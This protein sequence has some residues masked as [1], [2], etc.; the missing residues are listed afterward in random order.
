M[1]SHVASARSRTSTGKA[2]AR[3]HPVGVDDFLTF[4][5]TATIQDLRLGATQADV[6]AALGPPADTSAIKPLIW[7]YDN[8]E[9]TFQERARGD[10][11]AVLRS[12]R[13]GGAPPA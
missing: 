1:W 4:L 6:R 8:I 9:I 3:R 12:R 5:R 10:D 11:R 7:K 13:A 2:P